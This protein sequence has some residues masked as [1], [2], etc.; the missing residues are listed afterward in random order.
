MRELY[1]NNNAFKDSTNFEHIKTHYYWSHVTVSSNSSDSLALDGLLVHL[2]LRST[3]RRSS[4][5]DLFPTL[6]HYKNKNKFASSLW[7]SVKHWKDFEINVQVIDSTF[8]FFLKNWM[9]CEQLHVTCMTV[10]SFP[11]QVLSNWARN[12]HF[13]MVVESVWGLNGVGYLH[14]IARV[15]CIANTEL[16]LLVIILSTDSCPYTPLATNS[17]T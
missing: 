8:L 1:W 9:S 4:L 2:W 16:F 6:G 14:L 11:Q 15:V 12:L 13:A 3:P 17:D 5:A 10:S 7:V